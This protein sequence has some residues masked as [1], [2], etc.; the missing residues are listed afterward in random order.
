MKAVE[1]LAKLPYRLFPSRAAYYARNYRALRRIGLDP[2]RATW[3]EA[4]NCT[5]CGEAGRCPGWH[6]PEKGRS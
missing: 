4:G 3:D 6:T 1:I 2:I 5:V